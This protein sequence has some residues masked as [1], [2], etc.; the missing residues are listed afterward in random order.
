MPPKIKVHEKGRDEHFGIMKKE[1]TPPGKTPFLT[2]TKCLKNLSQN[3]P[4]TVSI[5]EVTKRIFPKTIKAIRNGIE[6]P[7]KTIMSKF[8]PN[9]LNLTIFEL[10]F[11]SPLNRNEIKTLAS[12]WYPASESVLFLP[13]VKTAMLK[14]GKKYSINK[15]IGYVEMIRALIEITTQ[16]GNTK[17]FIGTIPLMPPKF[18]KPIVELYLEKGIEAFAI[19]VGTKDFLNHETDFR[20]ILIEI[21][22]EV[23]LEKAFI[24]ACN[25]GIPRFV[26]DRS[27]ADDFLSLFAYVD[28]FGS[29]F[30]AK[31][32]RDMPKGV[33]RAKRF[34]RESLY[35]EISSYQEMCEQLNM[36]LWNA[37][38]FLNDSNQ[39][40][41]L[42]ETDKVRSLVGEE[43]ML[44]YLK[45]KS[46]VDNF[47]LR[48]L[49]SIITSVKSLW[50]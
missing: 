18:S 28:A 15:I 2:P 10:M 49:D 38:Q 36:R 25:L 45:E 5:N 6:S 11:N 12:Y 32:G 1:V 47:A 4:N 40:E 22:E 8:L 29:T 41:Q 44:T 48:R 50:R 34:L 24:Y 3:V 37:R 39:R 13:T 27:R 16:I 42:K 17:A 19:D 26:H 20:S 46:A 14:E 31:G 33:G 35:Y 43:K 21:N 9:K 7:R 23:S 30:K